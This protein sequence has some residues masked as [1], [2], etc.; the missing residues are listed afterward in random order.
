MLEFYHDCIV[1]YFNPNSFELTET[2]TD[3]IYMAINEENI[4]ECINKKYKEKYQK[5]I[6]GSCRDLNY[7]QWFPRRCC[8]THIASGKREVGRFKLEFEGIKMISLCSKS[9][10]IEN[11]TYSQ[12]KIGFNYFYCKRKILE[13]GVS[14]EP[15]DITVTP[16]DEKIVLVDDIHNPLSNLYQCKLLYDGFYFCSS[17]HLYYFLISKDAKKYELTNKILDE[18]D[19]FQLEILMEDFNKKYQKEEER[20]RFMRFAILQKFIQIEEFRIKLKEHSNSYIAYKQSTL[21]KH[22]SSF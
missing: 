14:T 9:Y 17:E 15:L 6:Y 2:D 16:W 22:D 11:D 21:N 12:E 10:I 8:A 5:E 13:D 3:S 20:E 7:T 18:T 1:K 19:P 4:D